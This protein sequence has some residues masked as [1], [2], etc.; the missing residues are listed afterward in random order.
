MKS[1]FGSG[2]EIVGSQCYTT[3]RKKKYEKEEKSI[4]DDESIKVRQLII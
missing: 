1:F 3:I 4:I 2:N